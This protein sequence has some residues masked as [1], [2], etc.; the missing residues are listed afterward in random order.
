MRPVNFLLPVCCMPFLGLPKGLTCAYC[1]F[2]SGAG[3]VREGVP[4]FRGVGRGVVRNRGPP[5]AGD[6]IANYP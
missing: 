1:R 6:P 4:P 5:L 2:P 3:G